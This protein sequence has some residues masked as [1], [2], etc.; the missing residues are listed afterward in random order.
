MPVEADHATIMTSNPPRISALMTLVSGHWGYP[1]RW[2]QWTE[3]PFLEESW[4]H[5]SLG[6]ASLFTESQ[7]V[8]LCLTACVQFFHQPRN[9]DARRMAEIKESA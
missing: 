1:W 7:C 9:N 3:V 4:V 5:G 8:T 2:W 6:Y